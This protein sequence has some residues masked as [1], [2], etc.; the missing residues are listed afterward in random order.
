MVSPFGLDAVVFQVEHGLLH[1]GAFIASGA[2]VLPEHD[3]QQAQ[4]Q[5]GQ[6][7]DHSQLQF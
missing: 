3:P 5:H 4:V 2:V 7:E 6:E 1:G